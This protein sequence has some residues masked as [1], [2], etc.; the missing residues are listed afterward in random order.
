MA[1]VS[2]CIILAPIGKPSTAIWECPDSS[3]TV[4]LTIPQDDLG[5]CFENAETGEWTF[6]P[7]LA[8]WC[9]EDDDCVVVLDVGV[10][11]GRGS[12]HYG[13]GDDDQYCMYDSAGETLDVMKAKCTSNYDHNLQDDHEAEIL[14]WFM[15]IQDDCALVVFENRGWTHDAPDPFADAPGSCPSDDV[16]D[17]LY[18][19]YEALDAAEES[20]ATFQPAGGPAITLPISGRLL[21]DPKS[22]SVDNGRLGMPD[23]TMGGVSYA[24]PAVV[25]GEPI[26]IGPGNGPLLLVDPTFTME[27]IV[28]AGP[29]VTHWEAYAPGVATGFV[30]PTAWGLDYGV[31]Q[32]WGTVN[33][34]LRGTR[35]P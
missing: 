30:T 35:T 13:L 29:N 10:V 4:F 6:P 31:Q 28:G 16:Q 7:L 23:F 25:I 26:V 27:A 8:P 3:S 34:H 9:V 24:H 14:A 12:D 22:G 33:V 18:D 32:T 21:L 5:D 1:L 19:A 11:S 17:E 20:F 2:G 15:E